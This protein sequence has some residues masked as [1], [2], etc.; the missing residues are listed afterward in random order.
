MS[1]EPSIGRIFTPLRW[2]QWLIIEAGAYAAWVDG[3]T[4]LD[5]AAGQG[6][7]LE[8]FIVTAI[9]RGDTLRPA[10]VA[11]LHAIEIVLGDKA[12]FLDRIAKTYRIHFPKE[13]F[14]TGDFLTS[15]STWNFDVLVGN[16]PWANFTDLPPRI[17]ELWAPHYLGTGLVRNKKDVLL[18]TS[19]ADLA[20]LI[21]KRALDVALAPQGLAAFFLPLSIF[22]NSGANDLF[23][24][25]P[26]S[27]HSYRVTN[28]WD[29]AEEDIF[30]GVST[31]YGAATF[32]KGRPQAWPVKTF[33]RQGQAWHQTFSTASDYR[34]GHWQR[35]QSI[36]LT[37]AEKPTIYIDENQRP[38]QG[39][40][41]C[42]ANDIFMFERH[43]NGFVNA[44]GEV[45][46]LEEDLMFP[47]MHSALFGNS[48]RAS[49]ERWI[50]VPHDRRSGR[51]LRAAELSMYA[52]AH[53][54]LMRHRPQ[55]VNRKGTLIGGQI[56]R[57]YWWSLL[58]VGPYSFA[59]W[60]VAWEALGKKKFRPIVLKGYWQGNQALHAF[61]P[62]SSEAEALRLCHALC[63][64]E[65]DE[66]LKGSSMQGT[67]NWAQPGRVSKLLVVSH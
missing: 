48:R 32:E 45:V 40:N 7:F 64:T 65:V 3:A 1:R 20:S 44:S 16:P 31:R 36:Q 5:P 12:L 46:R 17:K 57:G 61:C 63:A 27:Q 33:V 42:G 30:S 38:R 51:P 18:G 55:L 4:I 26:D 50:L 49:R 34:A 47:L 67:C 19:R 23:R 35:H 58:G 66:W 10:D 29:F 43:G 37:K 60:K 21:L 39:I 53:S 9:R 11:R 62:C 13:N 59:E 6:A 8:A 54:Y 15:P 52:S 14:V 56:K 24:P 22:F 41:T 2:A 28:L 25:Y